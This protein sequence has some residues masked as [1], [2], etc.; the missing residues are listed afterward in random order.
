[1]VTLALLPEDVRMKTF[2]LLSYKYCRM[3]QRTIADSG[4][5]AFRGTLMST[6]FGHSVWHTCSHK[7]A[8]GTVRAYV[9]H[10]YGPVTRVDGPPPTGM[11]GRGW[12]G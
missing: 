2:F 8:S 11:G 7:F 5:A 4:E 6:F 1:M 12:P 10:I 3:G 9:S